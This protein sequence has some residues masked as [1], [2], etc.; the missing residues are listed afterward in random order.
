MHAC[1]KQ[2]QAKHKKS[3]AEEEVRVPHTVTSAGH[4]TRKFG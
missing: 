4:T 2:A 1:I 3:N